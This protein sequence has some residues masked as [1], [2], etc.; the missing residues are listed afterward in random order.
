[1][2]IWW[3]ILISF[4]VGILISTDSTHVRYKEPKHDCSN[5][6]EFY[7]LEKDKFECKICHKIHNKFIFTSTG[8]GINSE[9]E[10][11]WVNKKIKEY[12]RIRDEV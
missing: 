9:I 1:M 8:F 10:K 2:G 5:D 7:M 4:I 11:F 12:R 6:A 3:L